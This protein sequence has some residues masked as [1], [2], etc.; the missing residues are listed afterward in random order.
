MNDLAFDVPSLHTAYAA[1]ADPV[2]M[3]REVLARVERAQDPGIFLHIADA[4]TLSVAALALS[5]FD[6]VAYPLWGVPFAVKDNIDVAGMPTTAAC[7]AFAYV[8]ERDATC[9]TRLRAAGAIPVGKTNLDQFATGLVGLRTP[10]APPRNACDPSLVP[11]GSSSGSAVAVAHGIVSFALG[12]DTAGSGRVPAA[13]N[14]IVGLKPSCGLISTVGVVPACRTLDTVSIF[15]LS[16]ADAERAYRA[17]AAYDADDPYSRP[18]PVRA[19][20]ALPTQVKVGVPS[21]VTRRFFGDAIQSDMFE[22]A[23]EALREL[24]AN[25]VELDFSVFYEIADLLYLGPWIAERYAVVESLLRDDPGALHPVTREVIGKAATLGAHDVFHGFYRFAELKR[26]A[27]TLMATVDMICVP[28]VPKLY[29]VVEVEADP[30]R[31]NA[32]LGTYTNFVNLLDLCGVAVPV[33]P[34]RDGLPGGVTL[35]APAGNDAEIAALAAAVHHATAPSA[36]VPPPARSENHT[37]AGELELAVV[38]AH[39]SGMALNGELTR[40]GARFLRADRTV[41]RYRL[42]ALAGDGP[43]RPGLV[44]DA[45]GAAIY[46]EVWALPLAAVGAFIK[47]IPPPLGIGTLE[48]AVSGWVKGFICEQDGLDSAI[49]ITGFGGWR[50][51]LS[52]GEPPAHIASVSQVE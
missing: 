33:S 12:T 7:P 10:F 50:E 24:G 3:M 9:V 25:I 27:Q 45:D 31:T 28:T 52:Q 20:S 34:R 47:D 41:P 40:H 44:R 6:P 11:G 22:G 16:V 51:F 35:L 36:T 23:L 38:G 21:S 37:E 1:G 49:D 15:A 5:P 17:V 4:D 32:L 42:Y 48:L 46:L 18:M 43:A 19:S 8:A 26:P 13:M 39:M 2:A 14:N 30:I 29:S